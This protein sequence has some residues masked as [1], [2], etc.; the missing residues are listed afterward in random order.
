[1]TLSEFKRRFP[2]YIAMGL[3][4]LTTTFWTYWGVGEMYYEGWGMPFPHPMRYL[5]FAAAC[6]ALTLVALTWPRVGG[7]LLII[8][9]GAFTAWWWR[10][11]AARGWLSLKWILG[12]FPISSLLILTGVL[13]L[14][15]GRYRR[16]R[17]AEGWTPP[18][19]WLRRNL[20]YVLAVGIP[21]LVVVAISA[22]FAPLLLTR[23]DDGDRGARLIEGNG[24]TLI[25]A[26]KGP[27]WNW[28]QPWD[29][30]LSWDHLALYGVPPIGFGDKPGYENRHTT[31]KDM[32][33]TGLCRYLSEDG[34]TLMVEPQDIWRMPTTDEIVRSLVRGGE[35]AGC[36]WDGESG[37][38]TCKRQPNKDTPLW[39]PDE[40][41]IYYWSADEYDEKKA[42]YVPYTGGGRYGGVISY[43]PKGW[44]NPRHGYRCVRE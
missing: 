10:L 13:F 7:W 30:H 9:G 40:E 24:V 31:M 43:Q 32:E 44:G 35:N 3:V 12:T 26:P 4:I 19:S 42:W 41:P 23:V 36:T 37:S 6:L 38:A 5:I 28:T 16:Q 18:K 22:Y 39:A 25:W 29:G 15:E 11:A 17:R 27:G 20:R 2:G 1:M 21:L 34:M 14:L 8:I 33:T